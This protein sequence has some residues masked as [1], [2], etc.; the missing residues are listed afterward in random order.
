IALVRPDAS[1]VNSRFVGHYLASPIAQMYI[2]KLND[3]GAKA[4]LNLPTVRSLLTVQPERTEQ[5]LIAE[6]LDE[7]DNRIQNAATDAKK[8]HNLK[9]SLMDSLHTSHVRVTPLLEV[10]AA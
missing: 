4:G 9:T 5:D 8:I 1:A 7:T 10:T 6:R 3:A 2:S